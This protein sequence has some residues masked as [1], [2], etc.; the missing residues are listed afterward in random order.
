MLNKTKIQ[1]NTSSYSRV[2]YLKC[3]SHSRKPG[4]TSIKFFDARRPPTKDLKQCIV[5]IA[6]PMA[7]VREKQEVDWSCTEREFQATLYHSTIDLSA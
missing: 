4:Y 1:Y 7:A 2:S 6:Y 3:F 5:I